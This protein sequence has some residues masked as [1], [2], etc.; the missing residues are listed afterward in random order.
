M[1]L[2]HVLRCA[3]RSACGEASRAGQ[4]RGLRIRQIV[5]FGVIHL[6]YRDRLPSDTDK[7]SSSAGKL[8]NRTERI[9]KLNLSRDA[10][11]VDQNGQK[12]GF[13]SWR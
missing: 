2:G 6:T 3:E 9:R 4:V 12:A 13:W 5:A 10:V 1:A 11:G 7:I 8:P